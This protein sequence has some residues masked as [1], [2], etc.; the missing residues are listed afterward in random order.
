MND[1]IQPV[2]E[3]RRPEPEELDVS[4]VY[5]DES[6]LAI[7]KPPGMVVHPTYRNWTGTLL[8]ALLWHVRDRAGLL[9]RIVTRLDKETSGLVLVALTSEV[10]ARIQRDAAAGRVKKE[11]LALVQGA[12]QPQR[13][14]ISLP[15][16]RDADDRRRVV[17]TETGQPS[18]TRYEV[19]G[20]SQGEHEGPPLHERYSLVRCELV[21][22]RTH[23][24]RVHLA[25]RGWP[26]IGDRLY[27][28]PFDS[29]FAL[30]AS[31]DGRLAQDRAPQTLTRQALHAWR[32]TLP[33][34]V[35]RALLEIEAPLPTDLQAILRSAGLVSPAS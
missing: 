31:N 13:G 21:T 3:R 9:P 8:N 35:S 29:P 6:L 15:L 24:I 22:G 27:G 20:S 5:E 34:P 28:R 32:V 16:A 26:I 14:T 7:D 10:H 12:P 11:Y 17:V 25:A 19:V 30:S 4:I 23:Q 2:A 18:E 33:H 1:T